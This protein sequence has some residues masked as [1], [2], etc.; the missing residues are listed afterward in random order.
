MTIPAPEWR[1]LGS[2]SNADFYEMREDILVIVPNVD[3]TDNEQTAR[4]SLAFQKKH[5]TETGRR[6]SVIVW[7]DPIVVQDSGAR[8]VYA[9]ETRG[10]PTNCYALVG[11]SFFAMASAS[12][13]TGLAKPGIE[14]NVFR[15]LA[16]AMPWIEEMNRTRGGK[17]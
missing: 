8:S 13:F 16:E 12:V 3:S 5:W 10:V 15:S 14:T 11:E 9:N 7:M 2:T 1:K 17:V 6:G 4:E